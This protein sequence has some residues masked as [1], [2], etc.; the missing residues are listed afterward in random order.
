MPKRKKISREKKYYIPTLPL[1]IWQMILRY[2][3]SVPDFLDPDEGLD[4]FPPWVVAERGW[5]ADSGYYEAERK[6]NT[7]RRVC[8]SWNEYL[9]RYAHRF[10]RMSDVIHGI[11]PLECLRTAIKLSLR[12]NNH[13]E[14][15]CKDCKPKQFV[16]EPDD[17]NK[18]Y[19]RFNYASL[20]SHIL[21]LERLPRVEILD[22]GG[23]GSSILP[24]VDLSQVF[25]NLLRFQAMDGTTKL[26]GVVKAIQSLP[27]LRHMYAQP[28]KDDRVDDKTRQLRSSN[29]TT[30]YISSCWSKSLLNRLKG[31]TIPLPALRHLHFQIQSKDRDSASWLALLRMVGKELKS[32]H[33]PRLFSL[34]PS[35]TEIWELCPNL[36]D[37]SGSFKLPPPTPPVGHP[38]HTLGV[39]MTMLES[40]QKLENIPP[41]WPSLR[42]L[43]I[44]MPWNF[45]LTPWR[46]SWDILTQWLASRGLS[47]QDARGETLTEYLDRVRLRNNSG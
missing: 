18:W 7:L 31:T 33:L 21:R 23:Y 9:E 2:S 10:V 44:N 45:W 19:Y 25:P 3:I 30:L 4:R 13:G 20:H 16:P 38:I 41:D 32:L 12:F 40:Q 36:E 15:L 1:E 17:H 35:S 24:E 37:L 6:R 42:T 28:D 39:D 34:N 22:Y 8:K 27:S 11:I 14:G 46:Q 26:D 29:L 47:M 5:S 43:R